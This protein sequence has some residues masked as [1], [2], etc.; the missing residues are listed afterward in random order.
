MFGSTCS[1][2]TSSLSSGNHIIT[3]EVTDD[4]GTKTNTINL[5]I[6][7]ILNLSVYLNF[8]NN[9]GVAYN[10]IKDKII[11]GDIIGDYNVSSYSREYLEMDQ[12][13]GLVF[14]SIE[15]LI[16]LGDI[17][18]YSDI[19]GGLYTPIGQFLELVPNKGIL[20][21]KDINKLFSTEPEDKELKI[22]KK[23]IK[24]IK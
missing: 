8:D 18:D 9:I 2:Q 24:I 19:F 5:T 14:D 22:L 1:F 12:N 15:N 10:L 11:I 20:Y 17:K 6:K 13:I 7:S 16:V 3:L 21:N 4:D 23:H